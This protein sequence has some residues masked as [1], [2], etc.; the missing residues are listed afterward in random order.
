MVT[1]PNSFDPN[2]PLIVPNPK[3]DYPRWMYHATLGSTQVNSPDEEKALGAG[4]GRNPIA[5]TDAPQSDSAPVNLGPLTERV[6]VL[7]EQMADVQAKL[8]APA[9]DAPDAPKSK[10][11]KG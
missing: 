5:P 7:E 3:L 2:S 6:Q 4:W 10:K 1:N 11:D 9:P 8:A